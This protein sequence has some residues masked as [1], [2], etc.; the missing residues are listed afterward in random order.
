MK[1][2]RLKIGDKV[3]WRG[4]WGT[5]PPVVATI[6]GITLCPVGSKHG[7]PVNS[8]SWDTVVNGKVVFDLT[9]GH[10]AYGHQINKPI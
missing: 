1:N 5:Q 8:V 7:D 3:M 4:A 6:K 2:T 10:W 9:N